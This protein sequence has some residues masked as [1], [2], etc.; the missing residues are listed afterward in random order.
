MCLRVLFDLIKILLLL[1]MAEFKIDISDF[2]LDI[3]V[4]PWYEDNTN[5]CNHYIKS[6]FNLK[7]QQQQKTTHHASNTMWQ[8]GCMRR[9]HLW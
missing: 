4:L 9:G 6:N 1:Q 8:E 2:F 7:Q 5:F 3:L